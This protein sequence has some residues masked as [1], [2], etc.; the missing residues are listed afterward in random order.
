MAIFLVKVLR[1]YQDDLVALSR[2]PSD[3]SLGPV[4]EEDS[5]LHFLLKIWQPEFSTG[6]DSGALGCAL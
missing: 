3:V 4:L 1:A 5:V 2:F 6:D